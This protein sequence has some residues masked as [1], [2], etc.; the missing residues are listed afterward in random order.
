VAETV[1]VWLGD[2]PV[3]MGG[4]AWIAPGLAS[5]WVVYWIPFLLVGLVTA[6]LI[7]TVS[8]RHDLR[9]EQDADQLQR[10]EDAVILSVTLLYWVL[11][12]TVAGLVLAA[13]LR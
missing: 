11:S 7:V 5:G 3:R 4:G 12:A 9:S 1:G 8:P 6:V 2:F 10:E 13:Y